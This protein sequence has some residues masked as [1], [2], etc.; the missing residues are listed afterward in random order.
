MRYLA[1]YLPILVHRHVLWAMCA[2]LQ[3]LWVGWQTSFRSKAMT[4]DPLFTCPDFYYYNIAGLI[5]I[6]P[7]CLESVMKSMTGFFQQFCAKYALVSCFWKRKL[8]TDLGKRFWCCHDTFQDNDLRGGKWR[9]QKREHLKM[10][11]TESKI[12]QFR[13]IHSW[14]V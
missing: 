7:F 8:F 13:K 5:F 12:I 6:F 14:K 11:K 9:I 4:W 2:I 10:N 1:I 3:L